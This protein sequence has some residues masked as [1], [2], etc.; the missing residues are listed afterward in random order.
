[1]CAGV[2]ELYTWSSFV[3]GTLGG[4]V[5]MVSSWTV[6]KLGVDDPLDAAAGNIVYILH[7]LNNDQT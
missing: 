6:V 5:Y 2:N 3:I 7:V 1:M 4:V